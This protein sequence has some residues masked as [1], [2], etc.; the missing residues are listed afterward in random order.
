MSLLFPRLSPLQ[1][2]SLIASFIVC[3]LFGGS[4]DGS[5]LFSIDPVTAGV[6][7]GSSLLSSAVGPIAKGI[8]EKRA[9]K[10]LEESPE[11]KAQKKQER[12][13]ARRLRKGKYGY[14]KARKR[15]MVEEAQRGHEAQTKAAA[16]D[17]TRAAA[18]GGPFGAGAARKHTEALSEGAQDVAATTRMQAEGQ[19]SAAALQRRAADIGTVKGAAQQRQA[20]EMGKAVTAGQTAEGFAQAGA[21]GLSGLAQAGAFDKPAAPDVDATGDKVAGRAPP[22]ATPV[23]AGSKEGV[24][25]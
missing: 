5:V 17:I 7:I 13:A 2:V 20:L 1:T 10:R 6:L 4:S 11:Y 9:R 19:S 25:T 18:T 14:S 8:A 3:W 16:A 24:V 21:M 15:E 23:A 12:K 22:G